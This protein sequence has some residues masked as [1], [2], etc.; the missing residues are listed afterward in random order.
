MFR[1]RPWFGSSAR[2]AIFRRSASYASCG[3][4]WHTS[5]SARRMQPWRRWRQRSATTPRAHSRA[6]FGN[7]TG[8][9]PVDSAPVMR[10]DRGVLAGK[11]I[12]AE[13]CGRGYPTILLVSNDL[14]QLGCAVAPLR[15]EEL[16][17]LGAAHT[18]AD[19]NRAINIHAVNLKY[20]LRNIETN[21]ANL[22]HGRLPSKWFASTQPPYGTSIPQNGRRPQHHSRRFDQRRAP[23]A[24]QPG[25]GASCS[26]S[27]RSFS[28]AQNSAGLLTCM[29]L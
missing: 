28:S 7:V 14:E 9:R 20:R 5:A 1:A 10:G 27:L 26:M 18:L 16:Q 17:H 12:E 22:A 25:T 11:N 15:R 19:H 24:C 2:R 29:E 13:P 21:R 3:S 4:V 6:R 8:L 23:Q